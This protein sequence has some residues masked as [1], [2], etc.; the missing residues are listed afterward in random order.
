MLVPEQHG[1]QTDWVEVGRGTVV[2]IQFGSF[3]QAESGINFPEQRQELY[4]FEIDNADNPPLEVTGVDALGT[5]YRIVFLRTSG[6]AYRVEYGSD[7][8]EKP[9]YDT[10]TVL[11]SLNRGFRPVDAKLGPEVA[12]PGYRSGRGLGGFL[13]SPAF[14]TLAI[15]AMVAVLAWFLFRAGQRMKEQPE[16]EV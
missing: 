8:A 4:R 7:T 11:A 6:R 16:Q 3:R 12:I 13:D 5:G 1:V 14:L 2:L 10:A 9:Q 15:I